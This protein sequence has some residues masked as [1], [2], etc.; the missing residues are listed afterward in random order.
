MYL[1]SHVPMATDAGFS[2]LTE[3]TAREP[4]YLYW[5]IGECLRQIICDERVDAGFVGHIQTHL[6]LTRD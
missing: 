1:K 5:H 3:C 4:F 6:Y 2:Y